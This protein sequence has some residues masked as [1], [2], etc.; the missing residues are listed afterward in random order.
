MYD[1]P[2]TGREQTD[3]FVLA[4]LRV[5]PGLTEEQIGVLWAARVGF[6]RGDVELQLRA[7]EVVC[8]AL[9]RALHEEQ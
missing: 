8:Q 6:D 1:A 9:S 2:T 4:A 5:H 3:D 7:N